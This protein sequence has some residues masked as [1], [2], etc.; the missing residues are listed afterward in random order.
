[1]SRIATS[2][3]VFL[4]ALLLGA[5]PG[6]GAGP[7]AERGYQRGAPVIAALERYRGERGTYPD[8]LRQLVPS[9]LP[10]GALRVPDRNRERY[11]LQ[12]RR[13][14]EGYELAFRYSGPGMNTCRYAPS[15]ARWKC[16]GYF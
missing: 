3:S 8:S 2:A 11:P 16:N 12:Y 15:T 7:V 10:D 14:A 13:T 1:M 9:F 6:P 4:G 5:C